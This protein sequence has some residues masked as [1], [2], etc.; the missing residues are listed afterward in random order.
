MSNQPSFEATGLA[1]WSVTLE[2]NIFRIYDSGQLKFV[3]DKEEK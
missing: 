3:W 2:R 1:L